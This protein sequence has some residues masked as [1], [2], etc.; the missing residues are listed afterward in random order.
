VPDAWD[1]EGD[2]LAF[3]QRMRQRGEQ[4]D[5]A[6]DAVEHQQWREHVS[7]QTQHVDGE[8]RPVICRTTNAKN[9]PTSHVNRLVFLGAGA[10]HFGH[11]LA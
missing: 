10:P 5:V 4:L 11:A 1:V 6:A 9:P 7:G 8:Y 3:G 2:H